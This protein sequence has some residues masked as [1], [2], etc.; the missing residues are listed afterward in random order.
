MQI[1]LKSIDKKTLNIYIN[2][3]KKN[4]NNFNN[5]I[6]IFNLPSKKKKI[7][8][9]KS[10]HVNKKAQEHFNLTIYKKLIVIKS[11]NIEFLK[12]LLINKPKYIKLTIKKE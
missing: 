3:I 4:F 12:Y 8:F 6:N 11:I 1:K 5:K 7:A 9:L 2:F 10:P